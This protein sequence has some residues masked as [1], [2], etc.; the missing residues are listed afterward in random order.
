M[1]SANSFL[2]R[3]LRAAPRGESITRILAAALQAVDPARVIQKAVQRNGDQLLISGRSLDLQSFQRVFLLGIGKAS[4][5]MAAALADILADRLWAGLV[6]TKQLMPDSTLPASISILQGGHPLPDERSLFAGERV[7]E[8]LSAL[9]PAD[10]LICLISG[11]ASAL[12][13]APIDG[14]SLT[15]MQALT[16][17]L[18]ASGASIDE[19]NILRRRLDRL[20]GGGIVRLANQARIVSLIISDVVGNALETIASGPTAPDPSSHADALQ[21]IDQYDLRQSAPAAIIS[22]LENASE[23]PK[24]D[25]PLFTN[26]LNIIVASSLLAAQAALAQAETEGFIPYLLRTDLHGEAR[27]AAFELAT[28]LRQVRRSGSPVLS[29]ACIVAAGETTVALKGSGKGGRNTE[30]ALAAVSEL[31]NFPGVM[32]VTLASDGEDG[33]TDAAGA[34]VTGD[35]YRQALALGLQPGR[36]LDR[37]DSYTFFAVLD[38]LLK[39]GSTGTNVNDLVFLFTL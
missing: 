6:V 32:L 36:Y 23:T 21:A 33:P 30:L 29:P 38:D 26:A 34:V 31:A 27:Q 24:A 18:L 9:Q 19:I 7:S 1:I 2:T 12:V 4:I 16:S 3:S 37:N 14:I 17:T 35:T 15:D 11:G 13:S 25:D 20:K 5:S 10:L 22:R 8:F 39:P 28:F